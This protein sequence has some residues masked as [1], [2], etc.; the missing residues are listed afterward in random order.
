MKV[1]QPKAARLPHEAGLKLLSVR[2]A[3]RGLPVSALIRNAHGIE[4]WNLF[5]GELGDGDASV[6]VRSFRFKAGLN[7]EQS[8]AL[9]WRCRW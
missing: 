9:L 7:P 6:E 2:R 8:C 3:L 1:N 4:D 5:V